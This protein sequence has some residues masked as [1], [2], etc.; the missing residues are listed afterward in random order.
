MTP[1]NP[2]TIWPVP[3]QFRTI[4]SHAAQIPSTARTV[5]ISG[6]IGI[7]PDGALGAD[8]AAQCHR[9][10]DNVEAVLVAA[11]MTTANVVKLTYFLTR[12]ADLPELGSIRRQRW[13]SATPP[14]VTVLVV[15][16]LARPEYLIEIEAVATA[17]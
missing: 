2:P 7:A 5:Y 17:S 14:A 4:Y 6:Q 10:M 9:A 1:L 8:F 11:G 15:A 3:E 12:S 16:G 13:A